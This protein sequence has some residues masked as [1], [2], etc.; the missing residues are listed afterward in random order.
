MA[1]PWCSPSATPNTATH[2]TRVVRRRVEALSVAESSPDV[3]SVVIAGE[4]AHF[5]AGGNLQR[6][7]GLR[8]GLS[9][10]RHPAAEAIKDRAWQHSPLR[11]Q[12]QRGRLRGVRGL[13][14]GV[15]GSE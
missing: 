6:L 15:F 12:G 9:L 3:R 13:R 8:N 2:S 4:G 14:T 7:L 10:P 5:C 1:R 11:G